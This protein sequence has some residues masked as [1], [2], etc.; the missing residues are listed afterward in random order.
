MSA[1]PILYKALE[2]S[3][4]AVALY[5]RGAYLYLLTRK[6]SGQGPLWQLWQI[7]PQ[8]D[9]IVRS[10]TLP[11]R[12]NHLLLA[13]GPIS[14]AVIEKGPVIQPGSQAIKSMLLLPSPWIED[15]A[16]KALADGN[17]VSCR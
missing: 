11:T 2:H 9:T 17:A 8:R 6:A 13:P 16:S 7:D 4:S 10:M 15:P 14:W 3:T 5:G 1:G 12:A